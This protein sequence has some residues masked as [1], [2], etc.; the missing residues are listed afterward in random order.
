MDRILFIHIPKAGGSTLLDVLRRQYNTRPVF[1]I[2]SRFGRTAAY[3]RRFEEMPSQK[4]AQFGLVMGHMFFGYHELFSDGAKYI[5]M[6]RDPIERVVSSY[7]YILSHPNHMLHKQLK[8]NKVSLHEYVQSDVNL[9]IENGMTNLLAGK[10]D[11]SQSMA[12]KYELAK[13]NLQNHFASIGLLERYDDSLLM[14]KYELGWNDMPVYFR[15]NTTSERG[16]TKAV[17]PETLAIIKERN[18]A[19]IALYE[20]VVTEFESKWNARRELFATETEKF[21]LAL[22]SYR[23]KNQ[24]KDDLEQWIRKS[25]MR[26]LRWIR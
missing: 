23:K 17:A 16:S 4:R 9:A 22:E 13:Q 11:P 1:H 19:D 12:D 15:K 14:Y 10:F 25:Y 21:D 18:W 20:Q 26:G 2:E 24:W 5:T 3:T 6:L 8:T 7:Y